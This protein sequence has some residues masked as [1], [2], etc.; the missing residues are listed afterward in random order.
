MGSEYNR[1]VMER[2]DFDLIVIGSG[3]GGAVCALRAAQAGLKVAVL[4]RG[5]R[6]TPLAYEE[7][8]TGRA[9]VFYNDRQPGVLELHRLRGLLALTGNAVGG[10]SN[11]YTAVTVR[12]LAETFDDRWPG[13]LTAELLAPY[14][15]RVEA[16]IAPTPIPQALSRTLALETIGQQIGA[17][18]TRLPL[19]MDWPDD[20]DALGRRPDTDGVYRELA[21]WLRGGR[22]ARK[23]TLDQTYIPQAESY[24]AEIRPLH[25]VR[26][27]APQHGGY[28]LDYRRLAD[29]RWREASMGTRR[30]VIAAGALSTPRLLLQC[31]DVLG[32]LP[33]LSDTLGHRFYTNGDFGGL[34][35]GPKI[36]VVP[37]SGPPVTAWID[38][39]RQERLYLM[40]TGLVPFD[41]GSFSGLLNPA[42]WFGGMRLPPGKRLTWSFGT[43]GYNDNPGQLVL[44]RGGVL[45]HRHDP[46]RGAAFHARTKAVLQQ[47]AAAAGGK[48]VLPP[49]A[50]VKRWPITVHPL[51]GAVMAD[52]PDDGVTD[53]FGEVFGYPGLYIADGSIVPT[54]TGV[55]PSMTIA[56]LA[57]RIVEHL[58]A[59]C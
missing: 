43:M 2:P 8:A 36:D 14:Y 3:F 29:G 4:E 37:D 27:I 7:L 50:M 24:G 48:L 39:W 33:G 30:L 19:S 6:M 40:E 49:A 5:R 26:A 1:S 12:A 56:A 47:F 58:I 35:V 22:A 10:G 51:G 16:M 21:T 17:D 20:S 9:P 18:V 11:V 44:G 55:P 46:A 23:R 41:L 32:T 31:R 13:G 15:D 28:R 42:R 38:L 57:E 25:E 53:C 52:S 54:P 59:Q 34:L 45:V